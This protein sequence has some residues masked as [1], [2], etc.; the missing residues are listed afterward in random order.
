MTPPPP[1]T[2]KARSLEFQKLLKCGDSS[3]RS[4]SAGRAV[5][6]TWPWT[7]SVRYVLPS[8]LTPQG[9]PFHK[10][11]PRPLLH[12]LWFLSFQ[13]LHSGCRVPQSPASAPPWVVA[14]VTLT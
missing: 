1:H 6:H 11:V 5:G 7:C 9:L 13:P 10:R 14:A 2:H 12:P 3:K 4:G 8:C